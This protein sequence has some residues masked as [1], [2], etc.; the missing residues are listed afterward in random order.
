M[1]VGTMHACKNIHLSSPKEKLPQLW[2]RKM[3]GWYVGC[4]KS[5]SGSITYNL[6][7]FFLCFLVQFLSMKETQRMLHEALENLERALSEVSYAKLLLFQKWTTWKYLIMKTSIHIILILPNFR[8]LC[9][10][11][12]GK[13]LYFKLARGRQHS[14][15][16]QGGHHV[17]QATSMWNLWISQSSNRFLYFKTIIFKAKK[18]VA[19]FI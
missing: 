1:C 17:N 9:Q 18:H 11:I 7:Y 16:K 2:R 6:I 10:L 8:A 19:S 13:V 14:P 4:F 3:A 5:F 15:Q 12:G